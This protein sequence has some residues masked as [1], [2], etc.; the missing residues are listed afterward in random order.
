MAGKDLK[1]VTTPVVESTE[2]VVMDPCISR[3]NTPVERQQLAAAEACAKKSQMKGFKKAAAKA[4]DRSH[5][6]SYFLPGKLEGR[7][8]QFL[9]D[10]GCTTNLLSKHMF[11]RLPER[12]R[13][14]LEKSDS[15]GVMAYGTQ[16]PF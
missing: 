6:T 4:L 8:V 12:V 1:P 16:L 15:N 14:E 9:V 2:K 3:T 7:P 10:T 11:S 5:T 13:S